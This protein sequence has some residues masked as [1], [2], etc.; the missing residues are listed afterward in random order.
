MTFFLAELK[1][2]SCD[3]TKAGDN[4]DDSTSPVLSNPVIIYMKDK[5]VGDTDCS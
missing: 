5:N 2:S 1:A 3:R 4:C